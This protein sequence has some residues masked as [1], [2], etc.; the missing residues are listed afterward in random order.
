MRGMRIASVVLAVGC[1]ALAPSGRA[2]NL[3]ANPDFDLTPVGNGWT[4]TGNGAITHDLGFGQPAPSVLLDC[5]TGESAVLSQCTPVSDSEIYDIQA[6]S[7]TGIANGDSF[8]EVRV[9]WFAV[10]GCANEIDSL[11]V[12]DALYPPGEMSIRFAHGISP[13]VGA[14]SAS[15]ELGVYANTSTSEQVWFDAI[16]LPEPGEN[17]LAAVAIGAIALRRR[18][19]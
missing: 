1:L 13:P 19:S 16:Y 4:A 12:S 8:N 7:F 6:R 9:R 2:Q 3:L 15:V 17:G 5:D 11:V 18:R 14:Q 10:E